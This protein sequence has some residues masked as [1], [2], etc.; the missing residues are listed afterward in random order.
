MINPLASSPVFWVPQS[1]AVRSLE[2][3]ESLAVLPDCSEQ[4]AFRDWLVAWAQQP[5]SSR[6][7]GRI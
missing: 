7:T 6:S 1:K 2:A 5:N 4:I 3:V